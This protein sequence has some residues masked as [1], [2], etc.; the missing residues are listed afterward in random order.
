MIRAANDVFG[1]F[2]GQTALQKSDIAYRM[3]KQLVEKEKTLFLY[4]YDRIEKVLGGFCQC[5]SSGS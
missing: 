5:V 1:M 3:D 4:I 2:T